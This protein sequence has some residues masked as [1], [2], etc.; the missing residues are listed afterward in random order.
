MKEDT[1]SYYY[2][3]IDKYIYGREES[4]IP[5]WIFPT[6]IAA[7]CVSIFFVSVS[8]ILKRMVKARTHELQDAHDDLEIKVKDRTKE[9]TEANERLKSLDQLKS[10]FIASMSHELRTPLTSIIGFTKM[11]LKGWVGDVNEE[12]DK[13]LTIILN[14]ANHLLELINDI[15]DISLPRCRSRIPDRRMDRLHTCH[16]TTARAQAKYNSLITEKG[17]YDVYDIQA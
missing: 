16:D 9:I 17:K 13:Q 14:S 1:S 4:V 15:I 12:Q 10:M 8:Y 3:I 2:R 7:I 11:I 6:L 5:P